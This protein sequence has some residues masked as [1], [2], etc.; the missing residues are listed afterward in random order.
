M[1]PFYSTQKVKQETRQIKVGPLADGLARNVVEI[2]R[3]LLSLPGC[4]PHLWSV[5][6]V[7]PSSC[8]L[9]GFVDSLLN[10]VCGTWRS[11]YVIPKTMS[12]PAGPSG[13]GK[14][15]SLTNTARNMSVCLCLSIWCFIYIYTCQ[16]DYLLSTSWLQTRLSSSDRKL[17]VTYLMFLRGVIF[18]VCFVDTRKVSS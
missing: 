3:Q 14:G 17:H 2:P 10:E 8:I 12:H 1:L 9:S 7:L 6:R 11:V 18:S 5:G 16:N 13:E 15:C 4:Q